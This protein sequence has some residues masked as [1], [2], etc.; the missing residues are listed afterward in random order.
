MVTAKLEEKDRQQLYCRRIKLLTH[1]RRQE[2][3]QQGREVDAAKKGEEPCGGWARDPETNVG[4]DFTSSPNG[5][6]VKFF[7]LGE[8]L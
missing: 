3:S 6:S 4:R 5:S 2:M 1:L 7:N 8:F